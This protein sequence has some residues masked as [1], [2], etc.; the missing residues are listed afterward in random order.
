MGL[1]AIDIVFRIEN[2]FGLKLEQSALLRVRTVADLAAM[3]L[4]A[5]PREAGFCPTARAFYELRRL[6]VQHGGIERNQVRPRARLVELFPPRTCRRWRELHERDPRLPRLVAS[7][8]ASGAQTW[9]IGMAVLGGVIGFCVAWVEFGGV[10]AMTFAMGMIMATVVAHR[11]VARMFNVQF[12]EG[13]ETVADVARAIAPPAV[14]AAAPGAR[15][16]AQQRVLSE[17]RQIVADSLGLS[18]E[19][20]RAESEL[21]RDLGME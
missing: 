15:L 3:V 10:A 17:V 6:L 18:S 7:N 11:L 9:L 8:R 19:E 12:P 21:V 13:I 14:G 4:A 1:D 20:V 5:L 16:I 2:R